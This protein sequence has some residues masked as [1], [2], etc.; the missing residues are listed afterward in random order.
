MQCYRLLCDP[1]FSL[2]RCEEP[3]AL[4][5]AFLR[6]HNDVEQE[7]CDVDLE[8]VVRMMEDPNE[9]GKYHS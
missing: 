7:A 6:V 8:A 4:V 5:I 3:A 1:P 2:L 9:P